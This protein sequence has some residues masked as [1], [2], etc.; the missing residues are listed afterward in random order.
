MKS[1]RQLKWLNQNRRGAIV[2]LTAVVMVVV[3]ALVAFALDVSYLSLTKTQLQAAADA[4]ALAGAMEL[5]GTLD[6]A[7][8]RANARQAISEV[9]AMQ[10]NGD[11]SS[12]S[13]DPIQDITFGKTVWSGSSYTIQ[14]GDDQFPYDVVKVHALRGAGTDTSPDNRLPL[15]F[16]PMFGNKS[17]VIGATAIAS[18]QPRDIM[19]V[20]DFSAS[21]NDDSSLGAIT[22]LPQASIEANIQTMWTELGS[23]VYGNLAF[24]PAYAKLPGR[25]A[26]GTIPHIDVTYKRASVTVQSTLALSQVRLQF[27]NGNTQNVTVSGGLLTGTYTGSGS[28]AGSDITSCWVKSGTNASLSAGNYGEQFNFTVANIQTALGLN[29]A[30]PY[31]AGSWTEYIQVVQSS[32]DEIARAGYRDMYG[33]LT[34]IDYL[35]NYYPSVSQTPD[36]WKTSEQPV[37][38]MKD[39]ATMFV[40]YLV[41]METQDQLGLAIYTHTS[42][43]GAIK[44]FGLSKNLAQVKSTVLVRQA[45]HYMGGTN[46]A[47]GM[48]IARTELVANARPRAFRMMVVST[49]GLANLPTNTTV[50][51]QNV[52]NEANLAVASKIK[53]LTISHGILADKVLMQQ[54]ADITGGLHFNVP[55]NVSVASCQAQ[56]QEIFRQIASS[57]PLKLIHN[58]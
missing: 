26:S 20:L 49:D 47:A 55:G 10:H 31:P 43:A 44:E 4:T 48:T 27:S 58:E 2:V 53:I 12:L 51:K 42:A 57:R 32:S 5:S 34:W 17:A 16:A 3:L 9:A 50:A 21:M 35:Q 56:L 39:A 33:Y 18:F 13:V 8:V 38:S 6:A 7:T 24:T 29:I 15:F 41:Q 36:L 52:I 19:M 11:K 1:I 30:Y 45:G 46:I 28:N 14:W 25:V 23:P 40:D 54:V 22:K 37:R